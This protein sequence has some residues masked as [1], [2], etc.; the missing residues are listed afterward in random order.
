MILACD[1]LACRPS[2]EVTGHRLKG[3]DVS[4][5]DFEDRLFESLQSSRRV[6]LDF[7]K[8]HWNRVLYAVSVF[9]VQPLDPAFRP[10]VILPQ[11]AADRKA[12]KEHMHLL[13]ELKLICGR[14]HITIGGFAT[15]GE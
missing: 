6:F 2:V 8:T 11:P 7:V 9:Q 13:Q 4:D 12:K 14:E 1:A 5:F 10:F 3:W 15:D